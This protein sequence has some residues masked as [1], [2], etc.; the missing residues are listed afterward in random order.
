MDKSTIA[1]IIIVITIISFMV[2]KIPLALTSFFAAI[3]MGVF[4]CMPLE[5]IY[6]GW[7]S[8]TFALS[9]GMMIVGNAVFETGLAKWFGD[10][11]VG[12]GVAKNEKLFMAVLMIIAGVMSAFMS[13]IATMAMFI[14]LVASVA[15]SS[16][17]KIDSRYILMPIGLATTIGGS[18]TLVGS[19]HQLVAQG[20]L[21]QSGFG[22]KFFEMGIIAFPQLI[23]LVIYMVTIGYK[24]MKKTFDF[25]PVLEQSV[26][27]L[28]DEDTSDTKLTPKMIISGATLIGAIIAF[29]S[30]VWNIGTVALL[31]A[32][33]V[34]VTGCIEFKKAFRE[35][36]W[37]TLVILATSVGFAAGLDISGGGKVIADFTIG[38]FGG[39]SASPILLLGAGIF[40]ATMLTNFAS[41]TATSAM[42][43]PIYMNIAIQFGINPLVFVVPI[44]VSCGNAT[45]TPVGTSAVTMTLQ[46][47]Y[48]FNDYVKVGLP[49]TIILM[50]MA[51]VISP[52]VYGL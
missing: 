1:I 25:D 45:F 39:D 14:P 32:G 10:K 37:N 40:I 18:G 29:I 6:A 9:M 44:V 46:G 22:M 16:K 27:E 33:I 47:G 34:M 51:M 26:E 49:I 42:L 38:L 8:Q 15:A 21:E 3:A 12:A 24:I 5:E 48:R 31:A 52:L 4:G 17:G 23:A 43:T 41:N 36:D 35:L 11:L 13:N 19:T 28:Q 20:I 50:I 30:G 2:E 7:G